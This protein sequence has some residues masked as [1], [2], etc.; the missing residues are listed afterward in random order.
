VAL[1]KSRDLLVSFGY[2]SERSSC[3]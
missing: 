2:E 1:E 3:K